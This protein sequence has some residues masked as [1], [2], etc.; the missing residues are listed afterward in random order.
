MP[1]AGD[2]TAA[3]TGVPNVSEVLE[4]LMGKSPYQ[5]DVEKRKEEAD[6]I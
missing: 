5:D 2:G 1:T 4:C 6:T 3:S